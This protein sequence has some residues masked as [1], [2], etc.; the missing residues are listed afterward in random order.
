MSSTD[1]QKQA[2]DIQKM[3]DWEFNVDISEFSNSELSKIVEKLNDFLQLEVSTD[4]LSPLYYDEEDIFD[5]E[6][7]LEEDI[8]DEEGKN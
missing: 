1:K 2:Q 7:Y 4:D 8:F 5:E 3:L 6:D